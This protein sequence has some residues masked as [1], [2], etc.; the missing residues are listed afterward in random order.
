M[1]ALMSLILLGGIA[2]CCRAENLAPRNLVSFFNKCRAGGPVTVAY[3]GGSVTNGPYRGLVTEWLRTQFP[4]VQITEVNAAIGGTG[5]PLGVFR[6]QTEVLQ[7]APDLLFVEFAI[8]DRGSKDE[9]VQATMEGIVRQAWSAPKKPDIVFVFVTHHDLQCPMDRHQAVADAYG[10]L[11]VNLQEVIHALVDPGFVDWRVLAPD[12]VHVNEW[13]GAIYAAGICTM[14]KR[15]MELQAEAVPPP[16]QL[17]PPVFSDRYQNA[18]LLPVTELAP[19]GWQVLE[20]EGNFHH[21]RILATEVGQSIEVPF[22]GRVV[23]IF[24]RTRENGGFVRCEVDGEEVLTVDVSWGERY[25]YD[26]QTYR[27]LCTDLPPGRHTLR[28]TVTEQ[29]HPL[30]H[31]HEFMLGYVMVAG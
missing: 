6:M 1:R 22:E 17:P 7:A 25:R 5:S 10:I 28:L 8:N 15:Q 27:L 21:G 9:L 26:L 18:R 30:S 31:G 23:G 11:V 13:G 3:I 16:E 12:N 19:P 24:Y 29:Q 2:M 4:Q 14:L 20:P